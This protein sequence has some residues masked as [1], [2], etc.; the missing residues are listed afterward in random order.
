VSRAIV[1]RRAARTEFHRA[2]DDYEKRR[3]GLGPKFLRN[4]QTTL[5]RIAVMPEM[6]RLVFRDAR[7]AI[8]KDFPYC[9]IY[10]VEPKR[11]VIL[12]IVHGKRHPSTWQS[13]V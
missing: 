11:V 10:R 12:A 2:A 13:R 3:P 9:I 1:F 6:H 5:D 4:V 8:V 7:R